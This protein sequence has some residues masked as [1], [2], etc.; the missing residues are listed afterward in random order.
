MS[1]Q[2]SERSSALPEQ[3]HD[4]VEPRKEPRPGDRRPIPFDDDDNGSKG[5][6]A[7]STNPQVEDPEHA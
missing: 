3:R 5:G 7:D 1:T 2:D 4:G 6:L